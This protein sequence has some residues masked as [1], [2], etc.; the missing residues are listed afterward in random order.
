MDPNECSRLVEKA[1]VAERAP[2]L[3]YRNTL[4][5]HTTNRANGPLWPD[6]NL[7]S[8]SHAQPASGGIKMHLNMPHSIHKGDNLLVSTQSDIHP[9]TTK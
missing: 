9:N 5:V 6:G 3:N 4:R 1:L 2:Q 7:A 8:C